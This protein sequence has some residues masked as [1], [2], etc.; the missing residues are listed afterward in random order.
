MR[1]PFIGAAGFEFMR[2]AKTI[3]EYLNYMKPKHLVIFP[4]AGCVANKQIMVSYFKSI[5]LFIHLG[6]QNSI[7]VAWWNQY[8][9]LF[10]NDIDEFD[11]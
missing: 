11:D 9:K 1:I 8:N 7:K 4:D 3:T 6:Y 2:S 10:H 5:M